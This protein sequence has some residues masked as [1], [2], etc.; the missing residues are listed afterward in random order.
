MAYLFP[1]KTLTQYEL[2]NK[3][4]IIIGEYHTKQ[5]NSNM[6][7]Q[8]TW[9]FIVQKMKEGYIINLEMAPD[10]HSYVDMAIQHIQSINIR[11]TLKIIKKMGKINN[12]NGMDFRRKG[13]FF[14]LFQDKNIQ[15][16][17]FDK[18]AKLRD[19]NIWQFLVVMDNMMMFTN[20]HFYQ[21][22]KIKK[23]LLYINQNFLDDIVKL[24]KEIDS[25]SR[26]LKSIISEDA[27]TKQQGIIYTFNDAFKLLKKEKYPYS[28]NDIVDTYRHFALLFSDILTLVEILHKKEDKHILLIGNSH[29]VNFRNYLGKYITYPYVH[30]KMSKKDVKYAG[31]EVKPNIVYKKFLK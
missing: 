6:D 27:K 13:E 11:E 3:K 14:G 1:A 5:I 12:V 30:P 31:E 7:V 25:H 15:A 20:K 9:D 4:I 19:V 17:F 24:H 2:A 28:F 16:Y 23:L 18:S 21:N 26:S 8:Y 29:A 10:F 22:E